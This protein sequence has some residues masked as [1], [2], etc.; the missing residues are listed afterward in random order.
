MA[1]ETNDK[2]DLYNRCQLKPD[3]K[4][5]VAG[6][7]GH[8]DCCIAYVPWTADA[9][10][11]F[12]EKADF[13]WSMLAAICRELGFDYRDGPEEAVKT[14]RAAMSKIEEQKAELLDSAATI[15]QLTRTSTRLQE[16]NAELNLELDLAKRVADKSDK[17]SEEARAELA[18]TERDRD[19]Y[20]CDVAALRNQR[21]TL[22][23]DNATLRRNVAWAAAAE[24][25]HVKKHCDA[26]RSACIQVADERNELRK[27]LDL[28]EAK[29][30]MATRTEENLR[31][32]NGEQARR[33]EAG[34]R[35]IE[36][37]E[38]QLTR[39]LKEADEL[40][41]QHESARVT[42]GLHERNA[43]TLSNSC[44]ARDHRIESMKREIETLQ[45]RLSTAVANAA[46]LREQTP[47]QVVTQLSAEDSEFLRDALAT[48]K[49][50][51]PQS[52]ITLH[53][54]VFYD[55]EGR[56]CT[57]YLPDVGNIFL[58][59]ILPIVESMTLVAQDGTQLGE[60]LKGGQQEPPKVD[61]SA[62]FEGTA[63]FE[64][65]VRALEKSTALGEDE[66]G[67]DVKPGTTFSQLGY[68]VGSRCNRNG[69]HGIL[70]LIFGLRKCPVC[71]WMH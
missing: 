2:P 19:E 41:E 16:S 68:E 18:A 8:A 23:D 69:C 24:L 31:T 11:R 7:P 50:R 22:E 54:V 27:K 64:W 21:N 3:G 32:M 4:E 38:A 53:R 66:L 6:P 10:Y 59:H 48:A 67:S 52:Y 40:R 28:A 43:A 44:A 13:R 47:P 17:E 49:S 39:S 63:K 25:G 29:L 34:Q 1:N 71:N 37:C 55:N 56:R 61:D 57:T 15:R 58:R 51:V 20:R 35:A 33:I 60:M 42:L 5:C 70:T 12:V 62:V 9:H 36:S 14:I 30:A 65:A 45:S 46:E 26:L